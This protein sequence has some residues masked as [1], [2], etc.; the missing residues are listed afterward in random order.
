MMEEMDPQCGVEPFLKA[1]INAQQQCFPPRA[2][3]EWLE[4]T[5]SAIQVATQAWFTGLQSLNAEVHV[6]QQACLQSALAFSDIGR[7][8]HRS[9]NQFWRT[10]WDDAVPE[11]VDVQPQDAS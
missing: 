6:Y 1:A 11:H 7:A 9:F 2:T 4:A 10:Q 3:L 5:P 8:S